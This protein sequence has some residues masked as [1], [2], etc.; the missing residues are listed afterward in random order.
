MAVMMGTDILGVTRGVESC[1]T[2]FSHSYPDHMVD[3]IRGSS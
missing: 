2:L 3:D 1:H